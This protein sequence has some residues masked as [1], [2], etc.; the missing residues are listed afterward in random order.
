MVPIT[1]NLPGVL[2]VEVSELEPDLNA[3]YRC[4]FTG[5]RDFTDKDWVWRNLYELNGYAEVGAIAEIGIGCATGVDALVLEWAI[6]K[7]VAWTR[8]VAD[9]DRFGT[10]AGSIRNTA[11]LEDFQPDY[12][13]V[14]PGGVGT[15]HCARTARKLGIERVF[16]TPEIDPFEEASKW[17]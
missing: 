17:G 10:A 2:C 9:W 16:L 15:T 7:N 8:Y 1:S 12:L 6:A 11:M 14:F 5:G 13:G 4:C 3:L